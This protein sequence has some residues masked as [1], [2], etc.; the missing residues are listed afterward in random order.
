MASVSVQMVLSRDLTLV[1]PWIVVCVLQALSQVQIMLV[2]ES[3]HVSRTVQM[4]SLNRL[5][6]KE[7]N[8]QSQQI[9]LSL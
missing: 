9:Q 7:L 3:N 4:I 1:I 2:V 8:L 6:L 5:E